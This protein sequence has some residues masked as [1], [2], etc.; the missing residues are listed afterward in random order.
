MKSVY[1]KPLVFILCLIPLVL[2]IWDGFTDQLGANPIEEISQRSGGWTLRLLLI[3]LAVTPAR[4]LFGWLWPLRLRRMLGLYS[5]FYACLH[6]LTYLVL[7]QFFEWD[8]ILKDILKRPYIT[9]GFTAFVLLVPLA[10]TSTH[11]MMR[12]LGKQWKKLH[13]LVYVIA[14]LGVLHYLW[15]V[16]ADY[17]Q[18]LIYAFTLLAL[19][20]ARSWC[21]RRTSAPPKAMISE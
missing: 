21:Q 8:E 16:K 18:P 20:L 19:L 2:G 15:L 12:R 7:D 5:F 3:T 6:F 13:Q 4:Q 10:I 14:V 17:L 9:V 11:A 1:I